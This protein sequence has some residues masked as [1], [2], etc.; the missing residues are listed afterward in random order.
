MIRGRIG[1]P[2]PRDCRAIK[3]S[4]PAVD[5]ADRPGRRGM[6]ATIRARVN[7]CA[8]RRQGVGAAV[9]TAGG[10]VSA[11]ALAEAPDRSIAAAAFDV[12][13]A[14]DRHEIA[15]LALTLGVILFAVVTTV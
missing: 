1:G 4:R 10:A 14:L 8:R 6:P 15:A 2:C 13:A 11:P 3:P 7:R 9:A 12:L 5:I